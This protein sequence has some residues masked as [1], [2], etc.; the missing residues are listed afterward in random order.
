MH[1]VPAKRRWFSAS[2]P[3]PHPPHPPQHRHNGAMP[4]DSR[5]PGDNRRTVTDT[6]TIAN[7]TLD[8]LH[9][10]LN[11]LQILLNP[12][13]AD[14]EILAETVPAA[15]TIYSCD[16]TNQALEADLGIARLHDQLILI[17]RLLTTPGALPSK[18]LADNLCDHDLHH[19]LSD[20]GASALLHSSRIPSGFGTTLVHGGLTGIQT[21]PDHI[22]PQSAQR[23]HIVDEIGPRRAL[24]DG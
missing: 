2:T 8:D 22:P 5:P 23:L 4:Y 3:H 9:A 16:I 15:L 6:D 7:L 20:R 11:E 24:N 21:L 14:I 17:T 10:A 18:T 13:L 19:L 1:F 12:I